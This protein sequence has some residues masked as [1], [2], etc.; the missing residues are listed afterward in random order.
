MPPSDQAKFSPFSDFRIHQLLNLRRLVYEKGSGPGVL[1]LHE[2]PGHTREFWRFA[3]WIADAGFTVWAPD[4]FSKNGSPTKP[5]L[6]GG[7]FRACISREINLIIEGNR[8]SLI[9][10]WLRALARELRNATRD[11]G[12]NNGI[13]VIGLCMT[14]NFAL[15]VAID[16]S[17]CAAVSSEPAAPLWPTNSLDLSLAEKKELADREIEVM[18]L[19]FQGDPSCRN[20]RFRAIESVIGKSR[21]HEHV[22]P[23]TAKNPNGNPWPHAVL[24]KD[25]IDRDGELTRAKVY[26]VISFF[27]QR[28]E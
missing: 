7:F 8:S 13:G 28:L 14:G 19:R 23:D 5:S 21:M 16:E 17:V 24:T 6:A 4:L 15:A 10:D 9:T 20:H 11:Q 3:H 18:A 26:D 25:L 22:L 12:A 27:R 1:L 2:L